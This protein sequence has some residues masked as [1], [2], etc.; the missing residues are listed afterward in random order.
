MLTYTG[1]GSRSTPPAILQDMILI[2]QRLA[3]NGWTL[4]TGRAQ[5]ADQAFEHGCDLVA[6]ENSADKEIFLPWNGFPGED[7]YDYKEPFKAP[8][9]LVESPGENA[10]QMAQDLLYPNHWNRMKQGAR[11]LHARNC[12]QVLG[13]DLETPSDLLICWAEIDNYMYPGDPKARDYPRGGTAT[14]WKL[15]KKYNI[16]CYNLYSDLDRVKF[17]DIIYP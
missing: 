7:H 5:G 12:Y 3:I 2:G 14:A 9:I 11:K 1:V 17:Y 16:P 4:R 13:M 6:T 8:R 10:I 15:A